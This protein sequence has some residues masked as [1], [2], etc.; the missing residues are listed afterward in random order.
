MQTARLNPILKIS[1]AAIIYL[2]TFVGIFG[3]ITAVALAAIRES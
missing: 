2:F 3:T 1:S